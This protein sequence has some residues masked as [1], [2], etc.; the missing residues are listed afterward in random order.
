MRAWDLDK[1]WNLNFDNKKVSNGAD[2]PVGR[3]VAYPVTA[4]FVRNVRLKF[5]EWDAQKKFMDKKVSGGGF[6]GIGPFFGGGSYSHG[7]VKKDAKFHTEGG[8]I[9]IPG[10]QLIGFINNI[11]PK[12]PNL[13]PEIKPE[14]LVGGA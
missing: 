8:S 14:Q 7:N 13:N 2:K 5:S 10:M 11:I 1:T 9:V 3:L 12:S 4:L 6:V